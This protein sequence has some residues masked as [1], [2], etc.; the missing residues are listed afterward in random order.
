MQPAERRFVMFPALDAVEQQIYDALDLKVDLTDPRLTDE[1]TPLDNSVTSAKIVDGTIV[2]AD[3][4]NTT[5]ES[6]KLAA[7]DYIKFD[8]TYAGGSQQPGELAWDADNETL[9]FQLDSHVTLQIGQEHVLRVKNASGSVAIPERTVVMF[10][11]AAGDTITVSPAVSNGTVNVNYLAGITT[12]EIPA[13]GFG[14]VTQLGFINQVNTNG[15][16]VGTLLYVDPATPGGLTATE[17]ESPAWTMPVAAVTKQSLTAGRMLVR[18]IPGGS[19]AGGGASVNISDTAPVGGN[20]GDMWYDSTDGTLYVYYED[21]DGSQWVQVQA[22]S[23]LTAGIESRVGAL[24]SQAIAFGTLSPN[25][26]LNG[27]FDIWQRG[28]S[29]GNSGGGTGSDMWRQYTDSGSGTQS[30]DTIDYPAGVVGQSYK[31]TA[32]ANNT[33]WSIFQIMETANALPLAGKTVTF[34]AYI[35]SNISR[36]IKMNW[37]YATGVDTGWAG[38]WAGA[39]ATNKTV[40][41]SWERYSVTLTV[42]SNAKTLQFGIGSNG[43]DFASGAT[44]NVAGL[45]VEI[46]STATAFRRNGNGIQEELASCQRHYVRMSGNANATLGSGAFTASTLAYAHVVLPTS[47]R[48]APTLGGWSGLYFTDRTNADATVSVLP[49]ASAFYASPNSVHFQMTTAAG[50]TTN[51]PGFLALSTS[52]GYLALTAEL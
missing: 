49:Q 29:L 33:N 18:S 38:S 34:S 40:T 2:N 42:P 43:N 3:I 28:T 9:E 35:K 52:S 30:K 32:G 10:A 6:A 1:R 14:F 37:N 23:A 17:P 39:T 25:L 12:E 47:M 20:P 13:D 21:V 7:Q 44:V 36:T 48:A 24:E 26:L 45:Q 4:A 16:T 31:F 11:G 22:N 19:G 5:I 15:W 27:A 8:T 50:G 51:R 46:G 41:T